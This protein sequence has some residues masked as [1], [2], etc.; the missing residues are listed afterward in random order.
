M[1]Y[2]D[3]ETHQNSPSIPHYSQRPAGISVTGTNSSLATG[4]KMASMQ[5][6]V[7]EAR[8]TVGVRDD[9][10]GSLVQGGCDWEAVLGCNNYIDFFK[11]LSMYF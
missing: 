2:R 7:I 10:H 5:I 1:I 8:L 3:K 9:S 11:L 4:T 6:I